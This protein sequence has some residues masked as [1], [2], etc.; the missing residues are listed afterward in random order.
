MIPSL[1]VTE[2]LPNNGLEHYSFRHRLGVY[3]NLQDG[4]LLQTIFTTYIYIHN[5]ANVDTVC[6][7]FPNYMGMHVAG[8]YARFI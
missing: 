7:F 5:I 3:V 6:L 8:L 1:Q 2:P 4:I